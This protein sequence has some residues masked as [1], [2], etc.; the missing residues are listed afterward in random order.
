MS[1]ANPRVEEEQRHAPR[2]GLQELSPRPCQGAFVYCNTP[3]VRFRSSPAKLPA[4]VQGA[5]PY[6]ERMRGRI[7][8]IMHGVTPTSN[9]THIYED[10]DIVVRVS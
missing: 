1:E 10:L 7:H 8:E 9:C 5:R 6:L 2:Q 3:G 4:P